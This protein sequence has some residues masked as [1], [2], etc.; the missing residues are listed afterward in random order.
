MG[1]RG[2]K[3]TPA[4]LKAVTGSRLRLA[5][6]LGEGINPPVAVPPM[7]RHL[8]GPARAEWKRIAP[9]LLELGLV[10]KLDRAPLTV[11]CQSW[12]D[13]VVLSQQLAAERKACVA[14]GKPETDAYWRVLPSGIARPTVVVKLVQDA[15]ARVDRALAH[16]GLSPAQRSRVTASRE[17]GDQLPL[18]GTE[19]PVQSKLA[20]L[21][22]VV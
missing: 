13:Y 14:A 6:D 15:E 19:D 7:P 20:Q 1:S 10:T 16:F 3:P 21:R 12:G 2:P 4:A 17:L 22:R 11:Y 18:P 9:H 5:A 8:A